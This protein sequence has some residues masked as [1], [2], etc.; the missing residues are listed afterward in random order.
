MEP[1]TENELVAKSV[2]K[3]VSKADVEARIKSVHYFT[4]AEGVAAAS[5]YSVGQELQPSPLGLLTF[6][7]LVIDNGFTV[8]GQS[9]CASPENFDRDIG[10]RLAYEDAIT[11]LWTYLGFELRTKLAMVEAAPPIVGLMAEYGGVAY[12]GTKCIRAVPMNR[13]DYNRLRGWEV[14]ADENPEDAGYLVENADG[15]APNVAGFDGYI[16]WSPAGIFEAT[17][18][19]MT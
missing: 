11:K 16:S 7:V 12:I 19:R 3:R 1:V 5:L 4:A 13:L 2:A 14:P 9:A 17:Y 6:A 8:T 15:G 10:K 18:E